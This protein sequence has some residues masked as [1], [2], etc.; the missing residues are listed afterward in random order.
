MNKYDILMRE[1]PN[2]TTEVLE[3]LYNEK[4]PKSKR[5]SKAPNTIFKF[6]VLGKVYNN[7]MFIDNYRSFFS[8]VSKIIPF[9]EMRL[10]IG[11][12]HF[13]KLGDLFNEKD[14]ECINGEFYINTKTSTERK[15][16]HIKKVCEYMDVNMVEIME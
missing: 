7:K 1:Y 3:N 4:F 13:S 5:P 10:A 2:E 9:D 6:K 16:I 12:C 8:D 14:R 11:S 15:I